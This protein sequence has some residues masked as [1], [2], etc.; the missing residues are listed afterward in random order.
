MND[1]AKK[2]IDDFG[3]QWSIY[4]ENDG[5]YGSQELF[6]DIVEPLLTPEA[7]EDK[8][9]ADIGSGAG[10]IV[11]M[12][13][14]AGAKKIYAVEPSSK[15]FATLTDNTAEYA[16]RIIYINKPGSE[17]PSLNLDYVISLGVIH[18]IPDPEPVLAACYE[19]LRPNGKCLIWLYGKEGNERYLS[20]ALPL[21][22]LTT[23]LPHYLLSTICSVLNI[24]LW[25][26]MMACTLL[27]LPMRK[28]LLNV[29]RPMSFSARKL[30]IY[31]QLNPA[32]AKYYTQDEAIGL[33]RKAGFQ[34]VKTHHRHGYSWTVLGTR[35]PDPA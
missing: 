1:V 9:V 17:L 7:F 26:Y 16:D 33:M 27:E 32:Y 14:A 5:F 2:T 15:A 24:F 11:N 8:T 12:L 22:R 18:H 31:D 29:I 35:P 23:H 13:A 3:D 10:R 21:R 6:K 25:V 30:V 34:D 20:V 19:T 28:Y 4:K